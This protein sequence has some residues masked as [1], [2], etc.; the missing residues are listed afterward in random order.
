M[1]QIESD[2]DDAVQLGELGESNARRTG[3]SLQAFG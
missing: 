3:S 1:K 2:L